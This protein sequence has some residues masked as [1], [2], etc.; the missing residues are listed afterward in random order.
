MHDMSAPSYKDLRKVVRMNHIKNCPVS[1]EDI[2]LAE[3]IFGKNVPV[4][5]GKTVRPK[6][7]EVNKKDVIDLPSELEIK[8]VDLAIGRLRRDGGLPQLH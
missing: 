8:E 1:I 6:S 3:R 7:K 2:G 5:K 4:L